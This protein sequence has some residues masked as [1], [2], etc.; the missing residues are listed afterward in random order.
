MM[1]LVHPLLT[2]HTESVR[3]AETCEHCATTIFEVKNGML[4]FERKHHGETHVTM[5]SIQQLYEKYVAATAVQ[6]APAMEFFG[7]VNA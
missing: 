1:P 4:I 7:G 5:I 3:I 2:A 6:P